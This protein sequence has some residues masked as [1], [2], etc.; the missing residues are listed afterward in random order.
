MGVY[1]LFNVEE[2]WIVIMV[3]L[4]ML[5]IVILWFVVLVWFVLVWIYNFEKIFLILFY[6]VIFG[7]VYI[8]IDCVLFVRISYIF[9]CIL[10]DFDRGWIGVGIGGVSFKNCL[11]D[12]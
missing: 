11:I 2:Y 12:R 4:Y 6:F 7:V 1:E 9:M 3:V 5:L 8:Y 10:L